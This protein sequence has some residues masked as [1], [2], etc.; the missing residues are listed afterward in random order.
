GFGTS[1]HFFNKQ[2]GW[3]FC[4]K[5]FPWGRTGC[6]RRFAIFVS[7]YNPHPFTVRAVVGKGGFKGVNAA[8]IA[9]R[10]GAGITC[11][12]LA[13]SLLTVFKAFGGGN[14]GGT[15]GSKFGA[16]NGVVGV[17]SAKDS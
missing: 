4:L 5:L 2:C 15:D 17:F 14:D 1:G 11:K 10:N 13:I 7:G 3:L 16:F 9:N 12:E 6:G 8:F